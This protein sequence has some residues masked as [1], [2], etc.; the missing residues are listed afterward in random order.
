MPQPNQDGSTDTLRSP[1]PIIINNNPVP[2]PV[3]VPAGP[4]AGA[5]PVK[6][7]VK[8]DAGADAA[9][10]GMNDVLIISFFTLGMVGFFVAINYYRNKRVAIDNWQSN[11]QDDIM[12]IKNK[13]KNIETKVVNSVKQQQRYANSW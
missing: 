4:G 9:K 5:E 2:G 13:L 3:P 6:E 11:T 10:F 7:P 1:D 12:A 8:A